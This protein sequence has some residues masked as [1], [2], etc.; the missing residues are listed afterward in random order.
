MTNTDVAQSEAQ[1]AAGEASLHGAEAQL[2]ITQA[3]YRRIIGVDP[4]NL[5]PA[6]SVERI[7]PS[8][9]NS[10]IAMGTVQNPSVTAAEYGVDVALLQVKIAEGAL[11]PTLAAQYSAQYN[12]FPQL[13]SPK[14]FTDTVGVNL[15]V[16]IYQGGGEYSTIRANKE[17]VGQQ[18]MNV[19]QVRDQARANVVTAWAQL[20]AAK[21]QI[22]AAQRQNA[23][24]ERA[25]NGVRN[26]AQVGQRT[27][28][29]VLIAEQQLGEC[30]A[31]PD[32]GAAR[33]RRRLLRP[34]IGCRTAVGARPG[35][36]GAGL[37]S[38]RALSAGAR[39]LGRRAHAERAMISSP[40]R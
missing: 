35:A 14:V 18:Q 10:A 21:A 36:A 28:Q 30:A 24:A 7:A 12:V 31:K 33:P 5:A 34:V 11:Y 19:D 1:L 40:P 9:L 13:L 32:R 3:N 22:E 20:Q 2:A 26:E 38:V 4:E 8:T 39:R 23:A 37:R 16:P 6:S 15:S 17:A 25:L 29:D 27:T